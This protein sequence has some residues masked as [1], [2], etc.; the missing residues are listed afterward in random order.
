[1][2]IIYFV[3][4]LADSWKVNQDQVMTRLYHTIYTEGITPLY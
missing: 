2:S 3:L 4:Q 1:M